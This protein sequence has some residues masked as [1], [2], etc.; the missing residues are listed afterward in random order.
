MIRLG[1]EFA[2]EPEFVGGRNRA[3]GGLGV[4]VEDHA[5]QI[6]AVDGLRNRAPEVGGAEPGA[7]VFR[8]GSARDLVEPHE[9]RIERSSGIVRE[10][11]RTGGQAVEVIAVEDVNQVKLSALEAQHLNVA[12]RLNI[13][14]EGIEMWEAVPLGIF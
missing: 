12:I 5:A 7:L 1:F 13:G 4:T 6:F 11:G 8:D 10:L 3:D 9:I 14:P 2:I